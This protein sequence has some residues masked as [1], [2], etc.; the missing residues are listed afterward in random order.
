MDS[1]PVVASQQISQ[2]MDGDL[3][4]SGDDGTMQQSPIAIELQ[5]PFAIQTA[6][7]AIKSDGRILFINLRD[8]I[9]VQAQ[10]NYVLLQCDFGSFRSRESI[11]ELAA[12]LKHF[13]FV[14]IHRSTLVNRSWVAEIRTSMAG[15]C[16]LLLKSG[17][18]FSVT[19]T[20]RR[21]LEALAELW[22]GSE[23]V[24]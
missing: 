16:L 3:P 7:M 2:T 20:Y 15:E 13:G 12:R 5:E 18:E 4:H 11:S 10:G 22:L 6:R 17:R 1:M 14:R 8:V 24:S 19:R 23:D 21:H 9:A